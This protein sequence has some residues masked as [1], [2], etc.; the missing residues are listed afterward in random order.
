MLRDFSGLPTAYR[1]SLR[2]TLQVF[3]NLHPA[4]LPASAP[5]SPAHPLLPV[6]SHTEL[7]IISP[8]SLKSCSFKISFAF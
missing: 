4:Y 2:S 6:S 1:E 5:V 7:A 3:Y 8:K